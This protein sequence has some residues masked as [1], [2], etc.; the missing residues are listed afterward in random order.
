MAARAE[1]QAGGWSVPPARPRPRAA[2]RVPIGA[3]GAVVAGI[4]AF[5]LMVVG[6]AGSRRTVDIAVAAHD[7]QPGQPVT[8]ADLR[9]VAVPADSPLVNAL[10]G[11]DIPGSAG[12]VAG[13]RITAGAPIAKGDLLGAAGSSGRR[14]MSVPVPVERANGGELSPGDRIDVID[15]SGG[16]P[17]Y[18]ANDLEVLTVVDASSGGLSARA[19]FSV[20]VSVDAE[21]ALAVAGALA[22]GKVDLVRSTGA[23]PVTPVQP[24]QQPPTTAAVRTAGGGRP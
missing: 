23:R 14:S 19:V 10:V 3:L 5:V 24:N 11:A 6:T 16:Q 22:G 17:N 8:S 15:T 4:L 13:H 2:A 7:I 18:V 20:S 21:Q 9:R 1:V 12:L